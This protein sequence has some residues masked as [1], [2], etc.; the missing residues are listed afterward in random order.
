[1]VKERDSFKKEIRK[2]EKEVKKI[3]TSLDD[4]L[5]QTRR[6]DIKLEDAN[7]EVTIK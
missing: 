4:E 5:V 6:L 1:M 7:Y 3:T 2:L